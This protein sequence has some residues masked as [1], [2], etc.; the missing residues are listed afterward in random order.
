VAWE[1]T[2]ILKK[3]GYNSTQYHRDVNKQ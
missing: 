3:E 2:N 1:I